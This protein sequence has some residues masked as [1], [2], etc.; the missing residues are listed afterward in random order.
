MKYTWH[1]GKLPCFKYRFFAFGKHSHGIWTWKRQMSYYWSHFG[2]E[3]V[4]ILPQLFHGGNSIWCASIL[5]HGDLSAINKRKSYHQLYPAWLLALYKGCI[6]CPYKIITISKAKTLDTIGYCQR[7]VFSLAVSQHMHKI[8]NLWKFELNWSL[9]LQD[10][11]GRKNT[12]VTRSCVL[13]E[14]QFKYFTEK[15]LSQN[16][17]TSEGATSQ[18]V[19]CYQHHSIVR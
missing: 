17:V 1:K 10:N 15:L 19:L 12:L 2:L 18:N 16:Y 3:V 14:N 4:L 5:L 7:P 9:K 11:N 8:T 13:S 6:I